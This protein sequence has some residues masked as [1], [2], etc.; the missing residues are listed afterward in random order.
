MDYQHISINIILPDPFL[1]LGP[2]EQHQ[3]Q[4]AKN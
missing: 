3:R 1:I 4:V 2:G